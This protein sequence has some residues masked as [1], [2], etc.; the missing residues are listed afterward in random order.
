MTRNKQKLGFHGVKDNIQACERHLNLWN[1][2]TFLIHFISFYN[3]QL[4]NKHPNTSGEPQAPSLNTTK[5]KVPESAVFRIL[6]AYTEVHNTNFGPKTTCPHN[7]L[8][9]LTYSHHK[10]IWMVR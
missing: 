5:G 10:H 7:I 4:K 2:Y 3:N 8:M 1:K 6:H 9:L